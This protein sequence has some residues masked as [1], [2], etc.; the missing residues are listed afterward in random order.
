MRSGSLMWAFAA[1]QGGAPN[2]ISTV[3]DG[4]MGKGFEA[5]HDRDRLRVVSL[6]G[7][8]QNSRSTPD[9]VWQAQLN[10]Q[11]AVAWRI[12]RACLDWNYRTLRLAQPQFRI[13]IAF[14]LLRCV[15]APALLAFLCKRPQGRL[16]SGQ[17]EFKRFPF[18]GLLIQP[19][20]V[21][22]KIAQDKR[23]PPKN[24]QKFLFPFQAPLS[25]DSRPKGKSEWIARF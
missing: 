18:L 13:G 14:T 9:T 21:I 10:G 22:I 24:G 2:G 20:R 16:R 25:G 4:P 19:C 15:V 12:L 7:R 5:V 17:E 6:L 8:I 3:A 1:G 23:L 11:P